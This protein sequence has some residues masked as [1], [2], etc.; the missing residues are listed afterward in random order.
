[1]TNLT[2]MTLTTTLM[3]M[4]LTMMNLTTMMMTTLLTMMMLIML[5]TT[6]TIMDLMMTMLLMT[7]LTTTLTTTTTRTHRCPIGLVFLSSKILTAEV[8]ENLVGGDEV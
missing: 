5:T 6:L 3:S 4:M 7:T 1:M 8:D 2:T